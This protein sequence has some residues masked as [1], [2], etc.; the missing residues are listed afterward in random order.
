MDIEL[1]G[2]DTVYVNP[3][4]HVSTFMDKSK[5]P[6]SYRLERAMTVIQA[7]ADRRRPHRQGD[8][9]RALF[10]TAVTPME[11]EGRGRFNG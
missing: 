9:A 10:D 8:T 11:S 6:D 1:Y 5:S 7:L 4:P 3:R 2:G